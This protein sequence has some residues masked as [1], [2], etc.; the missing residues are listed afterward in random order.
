MLA[1]E[2]TE[3]KEERPLPLFRSDL[4]L[5]QGPFEEN[6]AP[7]FTL[8]DPIITK[9]YKVSWEQS[10]I[11][12]FFKPGMTSSQLLEH[13]ENY[14][15]L[16][17]TKTEIEQFFSSA[18]K[19][20]LLQIPRKSEDICSQSE[21]EETGWIKWLL[22]HY[23]FI[24]IPIVNPNNFLKETIGFVSIFAS[25]GFFLLYGV[26]SLIGLFS[27]AQSFDQYMATFTYF[28]NFQGFLIY[29]LIIFGIKIIHEFAH[30]YT[31]SYYNVRVPTMGVA[32]LVLWPVLYTD[33][34]DCWK[35]A[36]RKHRFAIS[37]AGVIT[38]LIIAGIATFCWALTSPGIYQ[39][40][41]FVISSV[42]LVSTI[43]ININPAMRFDGYYLLCDW[44]GI[45]NLSSRS[46][47]MA[48]WR[49]RKALLG[50]EAPNPEPQLDKQTVRGMVVYSI[51]TW[52][53]RLIL[54]LGIAIFVYYK[55][56]KALGLFLF[57]LE[58][59]V[60][61]GW[62]AMSEVKQLYS[63]RKFLKINPYLILTS[64]GLLIVTTWFVVPLPHSLKFPTIVAP[65]KQQVVYLPN[66]GKVEK[67]YVQKG[68][69]VNKG[70]VLIELQIE[71]L[72]KGILLLQKEMEI[73]KHEVY[74][75]GLDDEMRIYLQEKV[76]QLAMKEEELNADLIKKQELVLKAEFSGKIYDWNNAIQ[77][78]D[79]LKV[80]E[81]VG[82]IAPEGSWLFLCFIPEELLD[83]VFVGQQVTYRKKN[84]TP[85]FSGKVVRIN[86]SRVTD[87]IYPNLASQYGGDLPIKPE[88]DEAGGTKLK[89]LESYY[90]MEVKLD[91]SDEEFRFGETGYTSMRGPW[92]S[93][94]IETLRYISRI[95][96]R[97][98]G[99]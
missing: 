71:E 56:T 88:D 86:P 28:F 91:E 19:F 94:F 15:T 57:I 58:L 67:L 89:M 44:W 29:A 17:I 31:A 55:F 35:L 62:P 24:R 22:F 96:I 45:D 13:I 7:S 39:S 33:V 85:F 12:E 26:V 20:S 49:L 81:I 18:L 72:E 65:N 77:E 66:S 6:G 14:S 83:R 43:L 10:V 2:N 27:L 48:R 74:I 47:T 23:L 21:R 92:R 52:I 75:L 50:M 11:L 70:D 41:F 99:F 82:K 93:K 40:I 36:N 37:A 80:D 73:L 69:F 34:T 87:L 59:I 8:F 68:D 25:K 53:Y 98:S 5:F 61:I 9:F 76:Q 79:I 16:S 1:Q 95:L 42:S 64:V 4:E 38:E 97:E 51:Y 84:Y 46:F 63:L 78:G 30:A 3:E 90:T 60:F 54:Y 32:F